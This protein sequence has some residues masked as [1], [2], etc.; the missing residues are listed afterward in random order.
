MSRSTATGG[1]LL[2]LALVGA[3]LLPSSGTLALLSDRVAVDAS[4]GAGSLA[5][6]AAPAAVDGATP[7]ALVLTGQGAGV[8]RLAT[9]G[10]LAWTL[11]ARVLDAG[12]QAACDAVEVGADTS[13]GTVPVAVVDDCTVVLTREGTGPATGDITLQGRAT[14][15]A[16]S[17]LLRLTLQQRP[18]GFSDVVDVPLQLSGADD[19]TAAGGAPGDPVVP[20]DGSG[21]P[22]AASRPGAVGTP[23]GSAPG[24]GTTGSGSTGSG[25]GGTGT[26]SGSPSAPSTPSEPSAGTGAPSSTGSSGSAPGS[27]APAPDGGGAGP[28][29]AAPDDGSGTVEPAVPEDGTTGEDPA[30]EG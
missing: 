23:P 25:S 27:S 13:V 5:I 6:T 10:D 20:A 9:T 15:G 8:V 3:V 21:G 12:G 7:E 2:G 1:L 29:E 11:Q 4:A 24:S 18:G 17:G 19:P 22:P 16:W 26:S 30:P 28:G 14:S